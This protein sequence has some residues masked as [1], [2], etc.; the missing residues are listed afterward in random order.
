[1]YL[2]SV[3]YR[4]RLSGFADV[5]RLAAAMGG[6]S[7]A[8]AKEL[9][10]LAARGWA[11]FRDGRAVGVASGWSLTPAGR[12]EADRR[13]AAEL[14]RAGCR[15]AVEAAYRRFLMLNRRLLEAVTDW[16]VRDGVVNDHT[17]ADHD[18]RILDQLGR[19]SEKISPVLSDLAACYDRYDR[20]RVRLDAALEQAQAGDTAYVDG[21]LID[22]YHS[23]WFELHED[24]LATL[25]LD[26]SHET[27][28]VL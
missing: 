15:P 25:G 11:R 26:R 28:E 23:V 6:S 7:E 4:L 22:S 13:L 17:N 19:I 5:D 1:M 24:L 18:Q 12:V 3:L 20:Y 10:G 16:Q 27:T 2:G 21:A 9:D 8:T 14:D